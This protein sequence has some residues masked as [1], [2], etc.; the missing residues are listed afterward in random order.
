MQ[1]RALAMNRPKRAVI[2]NHG[3]SAQRR[4]AVCE[5]EDLQICKGRWVQRGV[6]LRGGEVNYVLASTNRWLS[7]H[8][9]RQTGRHEKCNSNLDGDSARLARAC[10][11]KAAVPMA[12]P[13]RSHS[14]NPCHPAALASRH[15][16]SPLAPHLFPHPTIVPTIASEYRFAS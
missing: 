15:S 14:S 5:L 4:L 10:G 13:T 1:S 6:E 3:P 16:R 2:N 7:C 9:L 8:C 12:S 11:E